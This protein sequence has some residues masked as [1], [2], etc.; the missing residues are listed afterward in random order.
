MK[1]KIDF[2]V[3][4]LLLAVVFC[5]AQ[6]STVFK[7]DMDAM[8]QV[9]RGF[10]AT[11]L[12][13]DYGLLFTDVSK[14]NG[15]LQA[16]NMANRG[17]WQVLYSSLYFMKFNSNS[18]LV[19]PV[20][21]YAALGNYMATV[22]GK[23]VNNILSLH[24]NY[25]QFKTNAAPSLVYVQNGKI[26]DTPNRPTTPYET[27]TAFCMVPQEYL[28][29]GG[30]QVFRFRNELFF[31]NVS[32][33]ISSVQIDFG[34]G[35]GYR[36]VTSGTDN[37]ITYTTEGI[38]DLLF[39]ITY[40]DGTMMQSRSQVIVYNIISTVG[41]CS[42]CRYLEGEPDMFSLPQAGFSY[43]AVADMGTGEAWVYYG[44][45]DRILD[46]PLIIVEGFDPNNIRSHEA[47]FSEDFLDKT[48]IIDGIEKRLSEFLDSIGYDLIFLNLTD[49][50]GDIK[51]NGRLLENLVQWVN[52]QKALNGST[53]KNIVM[54]V[55]MGGLVA[56][57]G[58]RDM[59]LRGINHLTKLY[60]S[61][62]SPHLGANVPLGLQAAVRVIA[63]ASINGN[64]LSD[65]IDITPALNTLTCV[66]A[67]QMLTYQWQ[68][69]G[70]GITVNNTP[71]NTFQTELNTMG[72][73][74]M[75][76]IRRI[77]VASGSECGVDQGYAPYSSLITIANNK[78]INY[79]I[80]MIKFVTGGL[81][82]DWK[83]IGAWVVLVINTFVTDSDVI[84]SG[85]VKALPDRQAKKIFDLKIEYKRVFLWG[86][87]TKTK[88]L[89]SNSKSSTADML[90]LDNNSGGINDLSKL[91]QLPTDAGISFNQPRFGF[92]PTASAL[93]VGSGAHVLTTPDLKTPYSRAFP[94]VGTKTIP[95]DNFFSNP[96]SN[97]IHVQ[98]TE[99]NGRWLFKEFQDTPEIFS[100]AYLC[101]DPSVSPI[102][103][104]ANLICNGAQ[105]DLLNS[106]LYSASWQVGPAGMFTTSSG[107]GSSANLQPI[108]NNLSSSATL[109]FNLSGGNC[110][111]IPPVV[112]T[113]WVGKPGNF[114]TG[115]ST[116]YPGQ[117][118]RYSA[119]SAD[120][121]HNFAWSLFPW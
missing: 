40:T 71:H 49:G 95:F 41:G 51:R 16:N 84:T 89:F 69:L 65:V 115:P 93:Y 105:Y 101:A 87:G 5:N 38:K 80:N 113:I 35:L 109:T 54:G 2:L 57:Y 24:Y 102:I 76:G 68:G 118:Y 11:G 60:G 19:P 97:E 29:T 116:V 52:Q 112:K 10:V 81:E 45:T 77:A 55:S 4:S 9:N 111:T 53:E 50:G 82:S 88:E 28:L 56:R 121:S 75:W 48:M 6:N 119:S 104:G 30:T 63:G 108:S 120:E 37:I 114:I 8:F 103:S 26:Y 39:K 85:Y 3:L 20:D 74:Q 99:K 106:S 21:I 22:N 34:D 64:K 61:L 67:Q 18:A 59:E 91:A 70:E 25:E 83:I 1:L 17:V 110:G 62:D 14:F 100:C 32:K 46:K 92:I 13:K 58:L 43:P 7:D 47:M 33:T 79:F 86:L 98:V 94:P 78:D 72:L 31:K 117:V 96:L 42:N 27:R 107:T 12:L 66:A 73:P 36:V 23:R 90:P 44:G 15:T